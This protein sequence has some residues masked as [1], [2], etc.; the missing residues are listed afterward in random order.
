V[1]NAPCPASSRPHS[2]QPDASNPG[3]ADTASD[4]AAK[5]T[6]TSIARRIQATLA[7]HQERAMSYG[8]V[9]VRPYGWAAP[10]LVTET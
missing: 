4:A 10:R 6:Q 1:V 8:L 3:V 9:A 2:T 5:S 7:P